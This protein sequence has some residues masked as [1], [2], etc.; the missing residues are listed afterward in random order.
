[1]ALTCGDFDTQAE[2][3]ACYAF[4]LEETSLDIFSLDTNN[5]DQACEELP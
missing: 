4:C 5:N 3:Q 1:M 2:A